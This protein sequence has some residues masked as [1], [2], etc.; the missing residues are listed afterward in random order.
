ME[1]RFTWDS[2]ALWL[3]ALL[4][5]PAVVLAAVEKADDTVDSS[6]WTDQYD[7][8]FRKYT[9][10]YFGPNF[11]WRWFKA[12]GIAESALKPKAASHVGAQGVMQIMPATFEEIKDENPYFTHVEEPRWN[13]AAGIFYDRMLYKKWSDKVAV[14]D[15]R[16]AF[17]FGSYN[18]GLGNI[19][20]AWK[21]AGRVEDPGEQ[22]AKTSPFAPGETRAYVARIRGLMGE[23]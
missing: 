9:K 7:D 13:I 17:T 15:D 12:Q 4:L 21:R 20:N 22:W 10:R 6:R 14:T 16:L 23:D 1:A 18:A 8:Y 3:I 11:D 2:P 19:L 5:V